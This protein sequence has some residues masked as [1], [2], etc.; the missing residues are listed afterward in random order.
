MRWR[1]MRV[2]ILLLFM[3]CTPLLAM[4]VEKPN[5]VL[6]LSAQKEFIVKD[7]KG[8]MRTEWREVESFEP[9][10][11]LKYIITYR[12]EGTAEARNVTIVDPIPP[13]TVYVA[14]AAEGKNADISFSVDGKS[15][16]SQPVL[17]YRVKPP[18]GQEQEYVATPEMYTHI[19]W[20]LT[21]AVAPGET[22]SVSFKVKV[23]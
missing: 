14:N 12:N 9:G 1:G 5:V 7:G 15:F 8:K 6:K 16:Q 4:A 11:L 20:T 23:K 13:G 18:G 22:G 19:R 21:R 10:D 17:K 2:L 3:I